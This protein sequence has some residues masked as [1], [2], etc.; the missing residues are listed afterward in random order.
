LAAQLLAAENM[1]WWK[2]LKVACLSKRVAAPEKMLSEWLAAQ[3]SAAGNILL[4][5]TF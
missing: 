1:M 2:T 3:L 4:R 5:K